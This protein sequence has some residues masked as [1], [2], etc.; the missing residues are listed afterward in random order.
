MNFRYKE[1]LLLRP[2]AKVLLTV[3]DPKRWF[4]SMQGFNTIVHSLVNT[5]PY[6]GFLYLVGLGKGV[7][8]FRGT[9]AETLGISGRFQEAISGGEYKA[10][11]FF[12]SHIDEESPVTVFQPLPI[13]FFR[14]SQW[15]PKTN[16]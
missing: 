4:A 2:D 6:S 10:V 8:Y 3:R 5:F 16:S 9:M 11:E 15:Y 14:L 1:L 13:Y 7:D 12:K